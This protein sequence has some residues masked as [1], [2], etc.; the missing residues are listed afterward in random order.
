MKFTKTILLT[1]FL[2]LSSMSQ[3]GTSHT[4]ATSTAVMGTALALSAMNSADAAKKQAQMNML[5]GSG[6]HSCTCRLSNSNFRG[7]DFTKS[8]K[9]CE[10]LLQSIDSYLHLGKLLRVT[11]GEYTY[12]EFEIVD[13]RENDK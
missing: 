1:T 3:A 10:A 13:S 9:D 8:I 2:A 4:V 12:A 7:Y 11:D 6:T 5:T